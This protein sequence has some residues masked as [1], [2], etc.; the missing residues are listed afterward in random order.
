MLKAWLWLLIAPALLVAGCRSGNPEFQAGAHAEAVED[1]DTALVHYQRA[2]RTNPMNTQY[3]L[4]RDHVRFES[5]QFHVEQGQK[6]LKS[7]DLNLALAEFRRAQGIDPSNPAADQEAE[8]TLN[9][10]AAAKRPE[11]SEPTSPHFPNDKDLLSGPPQLKPLSREPINL[12][13]TNDSRVIFETVAKLAGLTALFDP[14]FTSRRIAVEL[15]NVTLE[16]ALDAI[17]FES[18]A[19]WKPLTNTVILVAPDQAQKRRDFEDEVVQTFYLS[20]TLAPQDLTEIVNALRQL[21]DLRR[22]Q[23]VNSQNAIVVRD[24]PDKIDIAQKVIRDIDQAKPEVLLHVSVLQ[25]SLNRLRDLGILPGQSTKLAFTPNNSS[26]SNC[27]TSSASAACTQL[28]L[29][30]LTHLSTA[31]YSIT[32]PDATANAVLTDSTTQI[33]QDPEMRVIDGQKATLKIGDRVPVATGSFGTGI[34]TGSTVNPLVNTQFQYIDVGVNVDVT[35]RIHPNRDISLKIKIEVSSV[36]GTENIGG[37]SQPIISQR[38]VDHDIRLKDGE[39]SILGG[40]LQRT[41]TKS[42]S[43][44]PGLARLPFFHYF[45][46]DDKKEVQDD[47]VLIVLTPHIIRLPSITP[48]NLRRLATGTD[49]NVRVY[50]EEE[51]PNP[52]GAVTSISVSPPATNGPSP[53]SPAP[54]SVLHFDPATVNLTAGDRATIALAISDV[55]DLFSIPLLVQYDPAVIQIEEVRNGGFLSGGT[56]EIAIVQRVDPAKGQAIISATRQPNSS[57]VN[58]SGTLFGL[59]IRAIAPGTS[60]IQIL[61]VNARDAQQK[62]ISL[63]THEATIQVQ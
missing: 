41:E 60:A 40:L 23:Q 28:T 5:G 13:I 30:D 11:A 51:N 58:G 12:K 10:L 52:V 33:I 36:T 20:N 54:V 32:L 26:G 39:V 1:F 55:Q 43:G 46:S 57:G 37:I 49:T 4:R 2:L 50:R 16:Q 45:F 21:F 62:P 59:V 17:A 61:Q 53:A 14:D 19:F 3:K 22:V 25:T 47:E 27:G 15:P 18:K 9:L 38:S 56:Q 63:V 48:E 44:W 31:D 42:I 35:P 8:R 6:A 34:G 7:G 29:N 24:T